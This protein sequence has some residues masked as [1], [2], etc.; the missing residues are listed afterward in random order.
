[1]SFDHC[2]YPAVPSL[3]QAAQRAWEIEALYRKGRMD[4]LAALQSFDTLCTLNPNPRLRRLCETITY[5][6]FPEV[7]RPQ[8]DV[9]P[10]VEVYAR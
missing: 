6:M 9:V 8:P 5:R 3:Q 1:M 10:D 2:L 4:R 7:A